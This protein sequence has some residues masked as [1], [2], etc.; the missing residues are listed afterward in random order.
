MEKER[1]R[2]ARIGYQSP[3]QQ[4]KTSSDWDYNRAVEFCINNIESVS[5]CVGSHNEHSCLFATELIDKKG[6]P[7]DHPHLCFS[8]LL[9]MSDNITFNLANSGYN[10]SKYVPYGPVKDVVPYLMRRAKENTSIGGQTSRELGLIKKEL[11][12]RKENKKT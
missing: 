7:H 8:Q 2:A 12:R 1:E 11:G 3:I 10:V 6:L 4:D 5:F 9:G